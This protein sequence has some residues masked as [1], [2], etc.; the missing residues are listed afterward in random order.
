MHSFFLGLH[1]FILL[2][3]RAPFPRAFP[4]CYTVLLEGREEGISGLQESFGGD[5]YLSFYLFIY[6]YIYLFLEVARASHLQDKYIF[7]TGSQAQPYFF[8]LPR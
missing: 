3:P 1:P 4:R 8:F 2:S 6:I 5:L 7:T